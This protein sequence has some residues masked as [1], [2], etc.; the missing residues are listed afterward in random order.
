MGGHGDSAAAQ[1]AGGMAMFST[2]ARVVR[3]DGEGISVVAL[4]GRWEGEARSVRLR[5]GPA[6]GGTGMDPLRVAG[7]EVGAIVDLMGVVPEGPGQASANAIHLLRLP[8]DDGTI[9][10][11]GALSSL[12]GPPRAA[13]A[14][15]LLRDEACVAENTEAALAEALRILKGS[16]PAGRPGFLLRAVS[17]NVGVVAA[18]CVPA[19]GTPAEEAMEYFV[20]EAAP[21]LRAAAAILEEARASGSLSYGEVVPACC[22]PAAPEH[23]RSFAR[24]AAEL[25]FTVDDGA[26]RFAEATVAA[27]RGQGGQ[28]L[29]THLS[30]LA[31]DPLLV[32]IDYPEEFSGQPI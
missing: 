29:A 21:A 13:S 7:L 31:P 5:K 12:F 17:P 15:V 18:L 3:L 32:G 22:I 6:A 16:A 30:P 28:W 4:S 23:A 20:R 25:P 11:P 2:A 8:S 27:S 9:V 10:F 24:L 1:N 26:L 19:D 14:L